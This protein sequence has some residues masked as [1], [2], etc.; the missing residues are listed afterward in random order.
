MQVLLLSVVLL[1]FPE[2]A[3]ISG[4]VLWTRVPTLIM[5]SRI[6]FYNA[7]CVFLPLEPRAREGRNPPCCFLDCSDFW[8]VS[9]PLWSSTA[10]FLRQWINFRCPGYVFFPPLNRVIFFV[11]GP[12]YISPIISNTHSFRLYQHNSETKWV[13]NIKIQKYINRKIVHEKTYKTVWGDICKRLAAL[14]E[15]TVVKYGHAATS[16]SAPSHIDGINLWR[17]VQWVACG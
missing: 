1:N 3:F 17:S 12:F 16:V 13:E 8:A 5:A 15:R 14:S 7:H 9:L 6:C 11:R 4:N 2:S 10:N